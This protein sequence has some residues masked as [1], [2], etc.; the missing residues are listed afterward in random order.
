[1]FGYSHLVIRAPYHL[2]SILAPL[3]V[4]YS[5]QKLLKLWLPDRKAIGEVF[6][7]IQAKIKDSQRP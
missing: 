6:A 1:M 2:G 7:S 4:G 5:H 3:M